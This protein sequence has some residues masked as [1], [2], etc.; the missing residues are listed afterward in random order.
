M[1]SADILESLWRDGT[2]GYGM[3]AA[4]RPAIGVAS[5]PGG[6]GPDAV[7]MIAEAW[8]W[9]YGELAA[10][11]EALAHGLQGEGI[12]RFAIVSNDI[13]IVVAL[14]AASS[15]IGVRGVRLRPGHHRR[16]DGPAG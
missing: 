8:Q 2:F 16:G 3:V 7:A 9:T 10:E 12:D 13:P 6:A 5:P 11:A 14:L 15:L 1:R 4:V